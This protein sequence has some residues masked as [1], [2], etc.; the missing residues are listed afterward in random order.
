MSMTALK[1]EAVQMIEEM[2]DD[3]VLQVI[4]FIKNIKPTKTSID[5]RSR[6]M[7][8]LEILKSFAGTL[9]EDFDYKKELC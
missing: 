2:Q 8:G 7:R 9:P 1:K 4:S 3:D 6:A 5:D